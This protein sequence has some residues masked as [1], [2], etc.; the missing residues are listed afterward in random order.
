VAMRI[1]VDA[2]GGDYAPAAIVRGAVQALADDDDTELILV[3]DEGRIRGEL[4]SADVNGAD[5]RIRI[6]HASQ[7]IAMDAP[8]VETLRSHKDSSVVRMAELAAA[9]EAQAVVSAG[10]TGACAA[11]CQ[12]KMKTIPGVTRPGIAVTIPS[13]HGPFVLCD[14]GAN[15]QAKPRHLYEYAVMATLYSQLV[16]GVE[17]PRVALISIGE[18]SGKGTGLIKQTHELLKHDPALNFV[19]NVEGREL[20]EGRCDVAICDG[21]V[22]NIV[23]K[24]VE[25]LAE[26][27]FRTIAREFEDERPELRDKFNGVLEHVRD[28]HDFRQYGGAPLLGVAGVCIICHGRSNEFAL[29]NAVRAARRFVDNG[30]TEAVRARLS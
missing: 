28:R 22:G 17:S 6:V 18:E 12:L 2:M 24:F 8:P 23:L 7:V 26:G 4:S 25:G 20:F 10:N 14:V 15:I 9:N 27:L 29:C 30:F 1:A 13:F 19:G 5:A 21:F 3:G 11:V 16:I